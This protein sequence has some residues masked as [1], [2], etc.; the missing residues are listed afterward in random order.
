MLARAIDMPLLRAGLVAVLVL[1]AGAANAALTSVEKQSGDDLYAAGASVEISQPVPGDAVLAGG[2]ILI[3]ADIT[4]DVLAAGGSITLTRSVGDDMRAAGG[5]I[6]ITDRIGGDTILAGGNLNLAPGSEV[7]G[8]AWLAGGVLHLSGRIHG[9][10]D[11]AGGEVVINGKLDGDARILADSLEIQSGAEVQGTVDYRG[12]RPAQ[13][14][15]GAKIGKLVYTKERFKG[16]G[17]SFAGRLVAS[18][19]VFLSLAVCTLLFG[20]AMPNVSR[21]AAG[22]AGGRMLL[23]LGVGLLT[24]VAVPI[25]ASILFALMLTT[26]LAIILLASY[27]V[28]LAT[29]CF[30]VILCLAGWL[31]NRFLAN[32]GEGAGTYILSVLGAAAVY[33]LV[34]LVPYIGIP[35]ILLA[36]V[37]GAGALVLL[38]ARLY[39]RPWEFGDND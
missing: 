18:L 25:V 1:A 34:S 22:N 2:S 33:W 16:H 26:P 37:T 35:V 8:N 29:G 14:A 10:V 11:A 15:T 13:V 19:V 32:R 31:R 9:D 12:P 20:W 23:S 5:S 24:V 39:R 17:V 6:T 30:V 4:Q 7:G 27:A 3:T 38:A 36:F 21:E 28:L